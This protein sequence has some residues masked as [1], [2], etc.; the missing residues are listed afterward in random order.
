MRRWRFRASPWVW[1]ASAVSAVLVATGSLVLAGMAQGSQSTPRTPRKPLAAAIPAPVPPT[2]PEPV[3]TPSATAAPVIQE[4]APQARESVPAA[5][6]T[7][8]T[9]VGS[10]GARYNEPAPIV[11]SSGV[12]SFYGDRPAK[13]WDARGGHALPLAP[14][15]RPL[16]TYTAHPSLPCGTLVTVSGPAG[17]VTVPVEDHGPKSWTGRVL[18]LSPATFLAVAGSLS[19]GVVTVRFTVVSEP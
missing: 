9:P 16:E 5:T 8:T 13:C 10:A 11:A 1:L 12:A 3:P 14:D 4:V 6:R 18:D 2:S 17:S 15:G 7:P 19:I